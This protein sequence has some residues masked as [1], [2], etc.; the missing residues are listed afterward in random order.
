MAFV[1]ARNVNTGRA[2][3]HAL[4]AAIQAI[5]IGYGLVSD[6]DVTLWVPVLV[7][8]FGFLTGGVASANTPTTLDVEPTSVVDREIRTV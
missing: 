5:L 3:F 2:A 1:F 8:V 4:L 6:A 7:S